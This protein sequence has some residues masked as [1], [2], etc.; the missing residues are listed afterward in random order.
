MEKHEYKTMFS[1]EDNHWWYA[2]LR[3]LV[4]SFIDKLTHGKDNQ[5]ILDAGCGTGGML[6]A[7]KGRYI[8]G[9]D[10]SEEALKFCGTRELSNV[11]RGSVCD[12]PFQD[13]SFQVVISLDVLYHVNVLDDLEALKEFNRVI[14]PKGILL[15]NLP[16]YDFLKSSHDEVIHTRQRYT[17]Q[18]V[19]NKVESAG[20]IVE[21]TTYRNTLLFPLALAARLARKLHL[22]NEKKRGSDLSPLPDWLNSFLK[23]ILFLENRLILRGLNFPFGL[24]VFCVARK[25]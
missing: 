6:A 4:L 15:L 19:K 8:F 5:K 1:V 18:D 12:M 7:C 10:I 22:Q 16:A 21:R 11:S 17:L 14:A 23:G 25:K 20:F 13:N 24:S 3:N 2:G 9:I